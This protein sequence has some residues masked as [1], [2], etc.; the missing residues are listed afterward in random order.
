MAA[1]KTLQI[2]R[3]TAANLGA[4]LLAAGEL[5]LVTDDG[6]L[7]SSLA[8]S[9]NVVVGGTGVIRDTAAGA[10]FTLGDLTLKGAPSTDLMAATKKYVD[11]KATTSSMGL[12]VKNSV[13][14]ATLID[15]T[16][17]TAF[18]NG[19]TIDGV[20]LATGDR[21]LIKNQT[22]G[23]AGVDNGIYTVNAS[24]APTRA[25]DM[26][27]GVISAEAFMFVEEGT[28][29]ET[30]WVMTNNGTVTVGTST[31]V[32][33]QF[34]AGTAVTASLGV[35]KSGNDFQADLLSTGG[36]SLSTN[37]M[38]IKLDG[39]TLAVGASGLKMTNGAVDYQFL[40]TTTTPWAP[41][42]TNI[43]ALAGAGMTATNGVLNVIA[44]AN[45]V[46]TVAAD[47]VG[48]TRP[49]AD[50]QF[51]K[52]TT[53]PWNPVWGNIADLAGAGL[54]HSAGVFHTVANDADFG[55]FA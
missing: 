37:S 25:T 42:Y 44:D 40:A 43:S 7:M 21:I 17:A 30:G 23:G 31:L 54:V 14:A 34:N 26:P 9:A 10:T 12:D 27:T 8:G 13:R 41:A 19:Q 46:I 15:G 18:A 11:D 49:A 32:F 47:A 5:G 20:T 33:A 45:N 38:Q 6:R 50:Y 2:K 16:L 28:Q 24:G 52:A 3:G 29:A 55:A 48:I 35:K 1:G 36:L 4:V 51:I 53:T 22:S 39:S